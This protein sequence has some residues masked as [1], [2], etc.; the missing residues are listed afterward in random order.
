MRGPP[1]ALH[2]SQLISSEFWG[3]PGVA[4]VARYTAPKKPCRTCRPATARGV[5]LQAASEKGV[6]LQGGVAATHAGV[7]LHCATM[8]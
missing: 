1:V 6:M 2:V 7:A 4:E 3:F 5:A 8:A